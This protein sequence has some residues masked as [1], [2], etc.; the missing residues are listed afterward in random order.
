VGRNAELST[1]IETVRAHRLVTL[2]GIGG[3]GKTR[4]AV[5]AATELSA[6]F[7]D[8]VSFVDL[9][10]TSDRRR[11]LDVIGSSLGLQL[12]PGPSLDD[13]LIPLL[14]SF[15]GLI[16]FDNCE[17][18][19]DDVADFI[20]RIVTSSQHLNVLATSREALNVDGERRLAIAGLRV[21]ASVDDADLPD[22]LRL[23][24][25]RAKAR[26]ELFVLDDRN[27]EEV[28]RLCTRLDGLPLAIELAASRLPALTV[29]QIA[30]RLD[31]GLDA[32]TSRSERRI[33]RHQ[34]LR[35]AIGWSHDLLDADEQRAF[36]RL[37]VFVGGFDPAGAEALIGDISRPALEIVEALVDKSLLHVDRDGNRNRYGY[38]ET[39]REFARERLTSDGDVPDAMRAFC[40]YMKTWAG[41]CAA[42][43]ASSEPVPWVRD[44]DA[45]LTNLQRVVDWA[46][47]TTDA[48]TAIE[49]LAPFGDIGFIGTDPVGWLTETCLDAFE[50]TSHPRISRV[51]SLAA[52]HEVFAR[53]PVQAAMLSERA[54]AAWNP[55]LDRRPIELTVHHSIIG[56]ISD[57]LPEAAD[58]AARGVAIAERLDDPVAL[59]P[60]LAGLALWS[61]ALGRPGCADIAHRAYDVAVGYGNPNLIA[62]GSYALSVLLRQSQP[63]AALE[64]SQAG[65]R[66]AK[67]IA[68]PV[69]ETL[70]V[71]VCANMLELGRIIDFTEQAHLLLG[72]LSTETCRLEVLVGLVPQLV[73]TG[74]LD[75]ARSIVARAPIAARVE[76]L[77]QTMWGVALD[78]VNRHG[79]LGENRVSRAADTD[80]LVH[81]VLDWLG[82]QRD[83]SD[84]R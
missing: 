70:Q 82:K 60:C 50:G 39:V 73:D 44:R 71:E 16:L 7:P 29:S 62:A 1:I 84:E 77:Y 38:L 68:D 40:V 36:A 56:L 54:V 18:V 69:Y 81:A 33:E 35:H 22:A 51:I 41:Q 74:H 79:D 67:S 31:Q 46:V 11:V 8:G 63:E 55:Q 12:P 25:A 78:A 23:F 13:D 17:H 6:D 48:N 24:E 76:T 30:A 53:G 80:A 10:S 66:A 21:E 32:L 59:V 45:Q 26:D 72:E 28:R 20:D 27:L 75:L 37:S 2:V 4:L 83:W 65:A 15:R 9:A 57:R 64:A 3:A 19:V 42:G 5:Q 52:A 58:V 14:R 61:N 47:D 34:T 43:L 49:L